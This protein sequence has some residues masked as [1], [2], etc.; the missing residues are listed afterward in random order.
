MTGQPLDSLSIWVL[1]ILTVL[2]MLATMEVGYRLTRAGQRKAPAKGDAG[3]GSMVGA[4]LALLAF[5]LAFVV[6][7]GALSLTRGASW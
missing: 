7:F 2:S 6:G 5:L 1:Y 3:V 4:S